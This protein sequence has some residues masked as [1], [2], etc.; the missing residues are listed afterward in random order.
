[1]SG[2]FSSE[3]MYTTGKY[4]FS[5]KKK[6]GYD[7]TEVRKNGD[8]RALRAEYGV[9]GRMNDGEWKAKAYFMIPKEVIPAHRYGKSRESSSIRIVNGILIFSFKVLF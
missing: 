4:K 5:Y 2:A 3:Y 8:V 1:M 9:F 7:T 6:N